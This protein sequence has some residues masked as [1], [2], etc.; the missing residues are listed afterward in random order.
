MGNVLYTYIYIFPTNT[1]PNYSIN[2][3]T[4]DE[5]V[6]ALLNTNMLIVENNFIT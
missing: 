5:S 4:R 2:N 6:N 1:K 3:N